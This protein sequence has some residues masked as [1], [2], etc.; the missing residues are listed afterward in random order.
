MISTRALP[1]LKLTWLFRYR[2]LIS[3]KLIKW[4]YGPLLAVIVRSFKVSAGDKEISLLKHY[5]F[6]WHG[7]FHSEVYTSSV[8]RWVGFLEVDTCTQK[9][10]VLCVRVSTRMRCNDVQMLCLVSLGYQGSIESGCCLIKSHYV[11]MCYWNDNVLA[12]KLSLLGSFLFI[13]MSW[14]YMITSVLLHVKAD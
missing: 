8:E 5:S 10:S 13:N 12:I 14:T 2:S 9:S 3:S 1:K 4:F 6:N 11:K 7:L